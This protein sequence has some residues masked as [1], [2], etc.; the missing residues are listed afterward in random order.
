M[1]TLTFKGFL[2]AY[3]KELSYARTLNLST[4]AK[5]A[6]GNNPRLRAPLLLYALTH[7]KSGLL[8]KKLEE[9]GGA[10]A[11]LQTL[12]QLEGQ[13]LESLL[14][15]GELSE[16]YRKLWHSYTVRR[17]RPKNDEALKASMRR[18]IIQLQKEKKCSNYRLYTD[19]KLNPGNINSWLKNGEGSKVSYQTA[20][21]IVTYVTRY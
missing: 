13:D 9:I 17:D 8:R 2:A 12:S 15:Q 3:V 20:Q 18:K 6:A 1:R 11:F 7:G 19:L 21:Q 16:E 5:E 10:D 14:A 4:L